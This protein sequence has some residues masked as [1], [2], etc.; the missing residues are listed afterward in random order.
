MLL[1]HLQLFSAQGQQEREAEMKT[2][3][4]IC[5]KNLERETVPTQAIKHNSGSVKASLWPAFL[6]AM[7]SDHLRSE[8]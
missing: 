8:N 1:C 4:C 3:Y 6:K 7:N 5:N 2:T